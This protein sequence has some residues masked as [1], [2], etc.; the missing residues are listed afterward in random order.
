VVRQR[1][2]RL[3][4]LRY[5]T[6]TQ[7]DTYINGAWGLVRRKSYLTLS[8]SYTYSHDDSNIVADSFQNNIYSIFGS[9]RF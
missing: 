1:S 8:V 6:T 7:R 9:L 4:P 5:A 3:Q 2:A